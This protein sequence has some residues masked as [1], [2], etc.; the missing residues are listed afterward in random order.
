M[1]NGK[2]MITPRGPAQPHNGTGDLIITGIL[3][4]TTVAIV[5]AIIMA[6]S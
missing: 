5:V 1:S 4:A 3:I 6:I 2:N